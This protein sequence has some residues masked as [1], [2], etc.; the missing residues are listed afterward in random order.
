MREIFNRVEDLGITN[1]EVDIYADEYKKSNPWLYSLFI[2]IG[3]VS[4]QSDSFEQFL[5]TKESLIISLEHE[6]KA[7][8]A[9]MR[10]VDGWG[11]LYFYARES[12]NLD[13]IV[14]NMLKDSLYKHE[15]SVVKDNKWDFYHKNLFPT[16][17]EFHNLDSSKIIFLL[18][19]EGDNLA[20]SREVEHYVSFDTATQKERFIDKVLDSG[21]S[22][23]DD[24]SSEEFEHGV[25]LLKE[26]N[27]I[28]ENVNNIVKELFEL[29]KQEHGY[30]EGWSTVLAI[31]SD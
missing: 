1:I 4:Q 21:F 18:K 22:F 7:K 16:E 23:K 10:I 28:E 19:E 17:L 26:H 12:K 14:A 6:N 9:G 27:I 30:Y 8:F 24:I 25:A 2:K 29:V 20:L 15:T 31:E 13:S 11:E 5:E 3:E